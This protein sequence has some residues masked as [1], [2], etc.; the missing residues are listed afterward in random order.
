V[1]RIFIM[2]TVRRATHALVGGFRGDLR[3]AEDYDFW[4]RALA[5]GAMHRFIPDS[6]GVYVESAGGKSKN[7]IPHARAQIR[8]FEDLSAM[9][10]LSDAQR[11]ACEGKVAAL[12]TRI[13]R[14]ELESRVLA[15]DYSGARREYARVSEAYLSKPMYAAGWV[16]MMLS[17][18]LYARLFAARAAKRAV[19]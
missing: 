2:A 7:R 19:A 1:D 6:L 15:G 8:I 4:L 11:A 5:L 13:A 9:R 3:Y 14:I 18:R 10:E 16:V 17:P 12:R